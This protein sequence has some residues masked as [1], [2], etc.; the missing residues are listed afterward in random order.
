MT[1]GKNVK[2][3][4]EKHVWIGTVR[5]RCRF[6]FDNVGTL[7][8]DSQT[9][10]VD[11]SSRTGNKQRANFFKSREK[12]LMQTGEMKQHKYCRNPS[13]LYRKFISSS[14][15]KPHFSVHRDR[16]TQRIFTLQF[17]SYKRC[18]GIFLKFS[19][20]LVRTQCWPKLQ[21]RDGKTWNNL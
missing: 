20:L 16:Q 21:C 10:Y 6:D 7:L 9:A 8:I 2:R 17:S 11:Y 4:I 13:R 1:A 5:V 12:F 19:T 14:K 18:T 15:I 3:S